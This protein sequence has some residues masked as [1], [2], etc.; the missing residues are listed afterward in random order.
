MDSRNG[1]DKCHNWLQTCV[2]YKTVMNRENDEMRGM[3][4][5]CNQDGRREK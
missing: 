5:D 4:E 1:C 2:K 3:E